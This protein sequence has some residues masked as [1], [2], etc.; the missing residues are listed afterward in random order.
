MPECSRFFKTLVSNFNEIFFEIQPHY[1]DKS[2]LGHKHSQGTPVDFWSQ[3]DSTKATLTHS[4]CLF[5]S[6]LSFHKFS[7]TDNY[8][9]I[10]RE[11]M[12][13][14]SHLPLNLSD[15]LRKAHLEQ[16]HPVFLFAIPV[17]QGPGSRRSSQDFGT[18]RNTDSNAVTYAGIKEIEVGEKIFWRVGW[19]FTANWLGSLWAEILLNILCMVVWWRR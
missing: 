12:E 7:S 9:L 3:F 4:T 15:V 11:R 6:I 2:F 10:K 19:N 14:D 8:F 17:F 1:I 18:S 5:F 13:E 16:I